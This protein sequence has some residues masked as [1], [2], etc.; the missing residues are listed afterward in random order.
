MIELSR[1]VY[2]RVN[3][4]ATTIHLFRPQLGAVSVVSTRRGWN[5]E[6][7]RFE[8]E[9]VFDCR[10]G[11]ATCPR[12]RGLDG[13]KRIAHRECI[14]SEA[15]TRAPPCVIGCDCHCTNLA[16]RRAPLSNARD[17][18]G[19]QRICVGS[20]KLFDVQRYLAMASTVLA[21][22]DVQHLRSNLLISYGVKRFPKPRLH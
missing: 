2:R 17:E 9:V 14:A 22:T 8:D 11:Q 16:I 21:A 18:V 20:R 13:R 4:V 3:P 7:F 12:Y 1:V 19:E 15:A 5:K 10:T 6:L